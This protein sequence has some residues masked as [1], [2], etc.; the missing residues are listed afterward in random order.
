MVATQWYIH[1]LTGM[2]ATRVRR[3]A[4]LIAA[5]RTSAARAATNAQDRVNLVCEAGFA[6]HLLGDTFAHAQLS[7]KNQKTLY[8]PGNGHWLDKHVPDD[9]LSRSLGAVRT[10]TAHWQEWV[11]EAAKSLGHSDNSAQMLPLIQPILE[12][13]KRQYGD[14][15][16][17]DYGETT[18]RNSLRAA[19]PSDWEPYH[20]AL[21]TWRQ[22]NLFGVIN[23]KVTCDGLIRRGVDGNGIRPVEGQYP[24]CHAVWTGYLAVAMRLFKEA[25]LDPVLDG[26]LGTCD[27]TSDQLGSATD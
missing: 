11:Q 25:R 15:G 4:G 3:V 19:L 13:K 26:K 12:S 20:P 8:A 27:A 21:E 6:M 22:E 18:L 10:P 2:E 9:I 24:N 7:E 17:Y 16:E 1:G 5:D 23:S 14:H